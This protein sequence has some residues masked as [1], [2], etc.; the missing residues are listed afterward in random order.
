[1][2]DEHGRVV[3]V[4]LITDPQRADLT[5]EALDAWRINGFLSSDRQ[6]RMEAED[7]DVACAQLAACGE[8]RVVG[9]GRWFALPSSVDG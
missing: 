8:L 7:L 3:D 5:V 4:D 6:R 1:M 2:T 9:E